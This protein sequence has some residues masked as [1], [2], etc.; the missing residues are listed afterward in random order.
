[1]MQ[2]MRT[3]IVYL[4]QIQKNQN[5]IPV[6]LDILELI[7]MIQLPC[8][9]NPRHNQAYICKAFS[10]HISSSHIL[11]NPIKVTNLIH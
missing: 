1:M 8:D 2:E 10:R 3:I 9:Q 5:I 4:K 7:L 11:S 6:F